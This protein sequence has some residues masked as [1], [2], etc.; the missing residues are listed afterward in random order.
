MA[1][2]TFRHHY[3]NNDRGGVTAT[4]STQ[5]VTTSDRDWQLLDSMTVA[6]GVGDFLLGCIG[7]NCG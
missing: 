4:N 5:N 7:E 1:I 6:P 2:P 3:L